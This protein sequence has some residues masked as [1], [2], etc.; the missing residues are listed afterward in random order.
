MTIKTRH[1]DELDAV[2]TVL[3]KLKTP[4]TI[5]PIIIPTK[6]II[7]VT[8]SVNNVKTTKKSIK[9][10]FFLNTLVAK[11]LIYLYIYIHFSYVPKMYKRQTYNIC[12]NTTP[13]N[14]L[15]VFLHCV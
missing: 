9:M 15:V 11:K 13:V 8:N 6:L 12:L 4:K 1:N 14:T 10:W 2:V 3:V 5:F 7:Q